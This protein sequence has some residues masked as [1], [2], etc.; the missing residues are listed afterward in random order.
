M[1]ADLMDQVEM[2]RVL[3]GRG[4]HGCGIDQ[5]YHCAAMVSFQP[6]DRQKMIR[7]NT[8]STANVVNACLA[9]GVK[10]LLH[11]SST[12]AIGRPP[13]GSPAT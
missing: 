2:I 5:V 10:K 13:E 8:E 7:F 11:V 6:R 4:M 3:E 1:D 12:S 9:A